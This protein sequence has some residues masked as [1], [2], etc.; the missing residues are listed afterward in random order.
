MM[1]A[2]SDS[3]YWYNFFF[4][5]QSNHIR[6]RK[7][8][9]TP[10]YSAE[11]GRFTSRWEVTP[12]PVESHT[13]QLKALT[14]FQ[15]KVIHFFC[16][17]IFTNYLYIFSKYSMFKLLFQKWCHHVLRFVSYV[18]HDLNRFYIY[19]TKSVEYECD[20]PISIH[21]F[22]ASMLLFYYALYPCIIP[23]LWNVSFYP[24]QII[25]AF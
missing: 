8:S 22:L 4:C 14:A 2:Q 20:T 7:W 13:F 15:M 11:R 5:S 12:L 25:F 16:K 17:C 1:Y 19:T 6:D 9:V 3:W 21:H 23:F 10:A 24:R 18:S